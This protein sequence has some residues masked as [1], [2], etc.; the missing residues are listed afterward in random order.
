MDKLD[1]AKAKELRGEI[2]KRL[3]DCYVDPVRIVSVNSLL[4]YKG[5]YSKD[6]IKRAI[7]YLT[8]PKKEF[9]HVVYNEDDYWNSF[10]QL[11]PAGINLAEGNI[12]D[13]GVLFH[14]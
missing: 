7:N 5:Y 11:T 3:Y 13:M 14:E 6:D 4:R 9:I 2:I 12:T 1:L 8:G 10:I